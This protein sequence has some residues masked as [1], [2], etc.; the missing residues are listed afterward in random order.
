MG[1]KTGLVSTSS[2]VHATPASF[3]A[4]KPSRNMHEEIALDMSNSGVD[5]MIGGGKGYFDR[6]TTDSLNLYHELEKK[7]YAVSDYFEQDFQDVNVSEMGDKWAFFTSDKEP[8]SKDAGRDYLLDA[9]EVAINFLDSIS[10]KG[11]FLMVEGSQID[12]AGHANNFDYL[13]S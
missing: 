1:K 12:W 6:R 8:L 7:G 5:L 10:D 11:F 3:A 2:I 4:H 13:V 9:S